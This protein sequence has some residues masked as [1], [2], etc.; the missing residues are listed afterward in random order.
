MHLAVLP[1][2]GIVF[3]RFRYTFSW[4]CSGA[5]PV[6]RHSVTTHVDLQRSGSGIDRLAF[7]TQTA[8]NRQTEMSGNHTG[9]WLD[10]DPTGILSNGRVPGKGPQR[11][12]PISNDL[13]DAES[14]QAAIEAIAHTQGSLEQ[15]Y[16]VLDA[17]PLTQLLVRLMV[18]TFVVVTNI[19]YAGPSGG[20]AAPDTTSLHPCGPNHQSDIRK[21][22][23]QRNLN[24]ST[25]DLGASDPCR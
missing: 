15:L 22:E 16:P 21:S 7:Q 25:G 3:V 2:I 9:P 14:L 19:R 20:Y 1:A 18:I 5:A 17:S 12:S 8:K 13:Q 24:R 6:I 11:V 10:G 4:H 23:R